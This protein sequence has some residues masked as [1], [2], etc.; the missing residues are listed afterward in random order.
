[1]ELIALRQA[2]NPA[3][4]TRQLTRTQKLVTLAAATTAAHTPADTAQART[5]TMRKLT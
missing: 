3:E 4:L 5:T 1:V 2:T